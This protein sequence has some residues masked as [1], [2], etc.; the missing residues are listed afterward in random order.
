V[1]RLIELHA[2]D[3]ALGPVNR[4]SYSRRQAGQGGEQRATAPLRGAGRRS[5]ALI[6]DRWV[7][8][9][10]APAKAEPLK[11]KDGQGDAPPSF[12]LDANGLT[13]GGVRTPWVDAPTAL[14][15]GIG[16]S[17]N[18][19]AFLVGSCEPFDAKTLDRLYPGGKKE[20]LKR[21]ENSLNSAIKLGFI[22]AA[23]KKEILG[24]ADI[25]Y[26]GSH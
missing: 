7:R 6:L 16:N 8:T 17:G 5:W 10:K 15:S 4:P 14:L 21:L 20:Y 23:D 1:F 19:L 18:P 3:G 25:S 22:L 9:G 2:D 26:R 24:L 13:V 12:E 11:L